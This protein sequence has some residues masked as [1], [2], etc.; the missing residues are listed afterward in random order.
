MIKPR[1]WP[2]IE[3]FSSGGQESRRLC[4]IQQQSFMVKSMVFPVVMYGCESWTIKKVEQR[5][6][7]CFWT[8]VLEKIL[9]SPL[10]CKEIKPAS[11]KENQ[12]WILFGNTDA[13]GE[14]PVLW[15]L[16]QRADSL[17]KALKLGKIEGRRRGWQRMRWMDGITVSMDMILGKLWEMVRDREAWRAAVHGVSKS[18]TQLGDWTTTKCNEGTIPV[19][20]LHYVVNAWVYIYVLFHLFVTVTKL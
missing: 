12:P 10:D 2:R 18:R 11:P 6:N 20:L 3:F 9:E 15:R 13:E 16:T 4:V 1:L 14:A 7:W 8:V 19:F 17:E 5:R